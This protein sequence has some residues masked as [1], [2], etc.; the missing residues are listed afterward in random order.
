[1][2]DGGNL[3]GGRVGISGKYNHRNLAK[4]AYFLHHFFNMLKTKPYGREGLKGKIFLFL[5]LKTFEGFVPQNPTPWLGK[6]S[7]IENCQKNPF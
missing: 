5:M 6:I 4:K 2:G 3:W 1:V 7:T